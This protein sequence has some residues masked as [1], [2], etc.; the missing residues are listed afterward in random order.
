MD[1]DPMSPHIVRVETPERRA[2]RQE[3]TVY[4][5]EIEA[6]NRRIAELNRQVDRLE[7]IRKIVNTVAA[8][9]TAAITIWILVAIGRAIQSVLHG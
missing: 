6:I 1:L 5:T 7:Q 3:L 2:R 8:I 4:L 9:A